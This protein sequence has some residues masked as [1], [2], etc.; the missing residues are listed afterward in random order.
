MNQVIYKFP[1]LPSSNGVIEMPM[2]AVVLTVQ[3]QGNVPTLWAS[4][5]PTAPKEM[6]SFF[7]VGT[8]HIFEPSHNARYIGTVQMNNGLVW[9]IYEG[10]KE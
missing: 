7:I 10:T 8:G 9:H 4:C 3:M 1:L 5:H 6:R 2:N